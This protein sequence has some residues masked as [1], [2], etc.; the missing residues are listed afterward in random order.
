MFEELYLALKKYDVDFVMSDYIRIND[1]TTKILKTTNLRGG[2]FSKEDIKK[3]IYPQ[4]IMGNNLDYGPLLSVWHCL[5]KKSFLTKNN[6]KFADDVRWS[7]DNLF[8]SLVGYMANSFYYYKNKG[9]YH[10]YNNQNSIS[11]SYKKESWATYS[12]MNQYLHNFF[13]LKTDFDFSKQLKLHMIYYACNYFNQVKN[14]NITKDEK[15][16]SYKLLFDSK[17]FKDAFDNF[18]FPKEW[19]WKLKIQIALLKHKQVRLLEML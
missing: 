13:D 17:Q 10:Y 14:A 12:L 18:S 2:Y 15:R 16:E 9:L 5:Y 1:E 8:S 11:T 4:L 7:E 19:N 3:E 6:L